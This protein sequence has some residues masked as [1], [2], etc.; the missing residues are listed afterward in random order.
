MLRDMYKYVS[1]ANK[2]KFSIKRRQENYTH[3]KSLKDHGKKLAS[4]LLDLC[5]G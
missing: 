4:I 1:S 2:I 5:L 3:W